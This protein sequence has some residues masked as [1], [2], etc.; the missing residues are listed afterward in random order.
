MYK[1]L[2]DGLR[3][4]GLPRFCVIWGHH[5]GSPGITIVFGRYVLTAIL[6]R[7]EEEEEEEYSYYDRD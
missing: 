1:R 4:I 6:G 5:I 7:L 3:L 2:P